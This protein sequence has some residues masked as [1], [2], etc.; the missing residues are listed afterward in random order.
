M[1]PKHVLYNIARNMPLDMPSL[2]GCSHPISPIVRSRSGDLLRV[3]KEAKAA[4]VTGPKMEDHIQASVL[5][6]IDSQNE[7]KNGSISKLDSTKNRSTVAP[8]R[9]NFS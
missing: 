1:M 4:G 2:L 9:Q 5:S 8:L 3:I 6:Q 7:T